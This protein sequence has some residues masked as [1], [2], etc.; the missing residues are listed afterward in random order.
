MPCTYAN[1]FS[2]HTIQ[3]TVRPTAYLSVAESEF[4]PH[5]IIMF[6]SSRFHYYCCYVERVS[7]A[8]CSFDKHR[9]LNLYEKSEP[10]TTLD[11]KTEA[12]IEHLCAT[13]SSAHVERAKCT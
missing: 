8:C 5:F 2:A 10:S 13:L 4:W 3:D 6:L 7:C 1:L 12:Q 11:A 9:R